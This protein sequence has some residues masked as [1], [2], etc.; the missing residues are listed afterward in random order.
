MSVFHEGEIEVQAKAGV[1]HQSARVGKGIHSEI[2]DAAQEFLLEQPFVIIGATDTVSGSAWASILF[3]S[4]GFAHPVDE[5]TVYIAAVPSPGDP[6]QT[7]LSVKTPVPIGLLAIEPAARS[8]MRLN[9]TSEA[10]EGGLLLHAQQVYANCPKYIQ[11][12][13]FVENEASETGSAAVVR[14]NTLNLEQVAWIEQA[15]TF[16]IASAH[17]SGGADASHRGG[18]PGFVQVEPDQR[19]ILFPDYSGNAMFNTLGNI[20]ATGKAGLLFVDWETGDL[21]HLSGDACIL[22][23]DPR[24]TTF[25]GSERLVELTVRA[26]IERPGAAALRSVG[27]VHYS[28]FNPIA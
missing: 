22:W 7:T 26:V 28:R 16:F 6:L 5:H 15:D 25:P 14:G 27:A 18:N 11:H 13:D 19:T 4:P 8:R 3:G 23:D 24:K 12:R 2:P 9:G 21:L 1:R 20:A 10:V 17:P